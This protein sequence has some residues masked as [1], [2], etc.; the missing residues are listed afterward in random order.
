MLALDDGAIARILI[1]A[2]RFGRDEERTA[3][4][5]KFAYI[6]ERIPPAYHGGVSAASNDAPGRSPDAERMRKYR[7]RLRR[8]IA[9]VPVP[10]TGAI[11]GYLARAG[12]LRHDRDVHERREIGAAIAAALERAARA[13]R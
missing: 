5:R 10:V 4:L 6:A 11:V 8:E 2:T 7:S 12:L 9:I 3:L 1:G 13:D